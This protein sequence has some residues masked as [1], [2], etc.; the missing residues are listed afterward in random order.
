[1]GAAEGTNNED[2]EVE[3]EPSKNDIGCKDCLQESGQ[4]PSKEL[5][6]QENHVRFNDV[7]ETHEVETE[8]D[9]PDRLGAYM[10][11]FGKRVIICT[12][13]VVFGK[14]AWPHIQP[15]VW[16]EAP[17][18]EG[19]LYVLTDKSFRGHVS[20]GDHFIMMYAPWC[21]HCKNLKPEWEKVGGHASILTP[22][23]TSNTFSLP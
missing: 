12:I 19:K 15:I 8:Y 6:K 13:L 7:V 2:A 18:K 21:G 14:T 11:G 10:K 4:A 16:P 1:M 3:P 22:I 9:K 17:T 23:L 20:R 5:F